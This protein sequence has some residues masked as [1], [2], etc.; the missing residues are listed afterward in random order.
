MAGNTDL[1]VSCGGVCGVTLETLVARH[2]P[3]A[4]PMFRP[5]TL[6]ACAPVPLG[7]DANHDPRAGNGGRRWPN[8]AAGS[9]AYT[10]YVETGTSSVLRHLLPRPPNFLINYID[11]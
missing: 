7:R 10:N 9:A 1:R 8:N 3:K 5:T 4:A 2:Y 6:E 11:R